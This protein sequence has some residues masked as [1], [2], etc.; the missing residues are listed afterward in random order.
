MTFV[1]DTHVWLWF[2]A[3]HPRLSPAARLVLEDPAAELVL[4][5]IVYAEACWIVEH[6]RL[7]G[8]TVADLQAALAADPRFTI[9]PLDRAVIDGSQGLPAVNE[10][11]DRQIVTTALALATPT[12]PVA[13]LTRDQNITASGLVPVIW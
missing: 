1:V 12:H 3:G 9:C 7:P 10:M 8:L 11:H 13:L 5:A 2:L 4:P 6:G